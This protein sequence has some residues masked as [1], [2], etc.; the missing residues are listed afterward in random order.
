MASPQT[1]QH[2]LNRSTCILGRGFFLLHYTSRLPYNVA[3]AVIMRV[4]R[5]T[6][7]VGFAFDPLML[8]V[9]VEYSKQESLIPFLVDITQEHFLSP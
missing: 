6:G 4:F 8:A 5:A 9:E 2:W 3:G 1:F 7:E